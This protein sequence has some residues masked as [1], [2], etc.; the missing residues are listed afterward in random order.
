VGVWL[1]S[2]YGRARTIWNLYE[3]VTLDLQNTVSG[4]LLAPQ[5][6]M[7]SVDDQDINGVVV[8][9]TLNTQGE[10]HHP[11]L[12]FPTSL[13]RCQSTGTTTSSP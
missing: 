5:A 1:T 13:V 4:S 12:N 3:A 9:H 11:Y 8:I 7:T 2:D 6:T 10:I